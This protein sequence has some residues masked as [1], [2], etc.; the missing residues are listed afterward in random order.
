M[1][2]ITN[3]AQYVAVILCC[4]ATYCGYWLGRDAGAKKAGML[5]LDMLEAEG[6]IS[7]DKDGQLVTKN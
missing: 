2:L 1:D 3:N 7:F 5:M 6:A 4:I